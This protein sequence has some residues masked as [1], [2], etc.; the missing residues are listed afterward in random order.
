[1]LQK[2]FFY[3][4]MSAALIASVLLAARVP[5]VS[6]QDSQPGKVEFTAYEGNP[7]LE[8]G[9]TG[10]WDSQAIYGPSVVFHDGLY[11]MFYGGGYAGWTG[12]AIGYAT[13]PD[14]LVWEKYPGNPVLEAD[15]T[16]FD[17]D[18]VVS[19]LVAVEGDTWVLYYLAQDQWG[20]TSRSGI[21]RATAPSPSGPWTRGDEP[22]LTRGSQG[23]WDY[24]DVA[25]FSVIA[26]GDGYVM[27]YVGGIS[28]SLRGAMIG[29]ATSPDGI[30][31]TKY[32][33]PM[34]TDP[35][36]SESDPVLQRDPDGWDM[37]DLAGGCVVQS[38]EGW[39]MFYSGRGQVEGS[40]PIAYRIGYAASDDGIHWTKYEGNPI[41]TPEDDP[42]EPADTHADLDLVSAIVRDST[43]LLYYDYLWQYGGGIGVA[44]GTVTR[45]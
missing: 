5:L 7:V 9:P 15:G 6:G 37:V 18:A 17:A 41:L 2:R 11:Y 3:V 45:E 1:L 4:V 36:Y 35:P 31:W 27:Y 21:G 32:D 33:D 40:G 39:E 16:G 10:A 34:T 28:L 26:T 13:S 24:S 25:A 12:A 19:A 29:M 23:E 42:A 43:Y 30:H 20:A 38:A 14:G 8:K 22:V 44:T